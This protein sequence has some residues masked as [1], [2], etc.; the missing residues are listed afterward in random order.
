VGWLNINLNSCG[1]FL[2]L[3]PPQMTGDP[4]PWV[5]AEQNNVEP[6]ETTAV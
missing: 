6:E 1:G 5:Q 2:A 4:G 3:A